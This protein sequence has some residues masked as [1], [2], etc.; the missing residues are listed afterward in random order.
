MKT[1][2]AD[3]RE[4]CLL[5]YA[6][7]EPSPFVP[8]SAGRKWAWRG[9]HRLDAEGRFVC[10][11]KSWR[12]AR[13]CVKVSEAGHFHR[14]TLARSTKGELG[15]FERGTTV[16]SV[17]KL[18]GRLIE[19]VVTWEEWLAYQA[20]RERFESYGGGAGRGYRAW[21][22]PGVHGKA[23]GGKAMWKGKHAGG[24]GEGFKCLYITVLRK[25]LRVREEAGGCG[26]CGRLR[27][28]GQADE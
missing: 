1:W 23:P 6:P 20:F 13:D 3:V 10:G 17:C 25:G 12:Q 9:K 15:Q 18:C 5:D 11:Y 26:R 14:D 27:S 19:S 2:L 7:E 8:S 21:Y 4:E 28:E 16:G 22:E 24:A